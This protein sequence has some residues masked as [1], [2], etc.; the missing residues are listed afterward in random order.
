VQGQFRVNSE[1]VMTFSEYGLKEKNKPKV[2]VECK[3]SDTVLSP[4][5]LWFQE[6][7]SVPV[8]IQVIQAPGHASR[9]TLGGRT[10]W[11][12]SADRWLTKLV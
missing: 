1:K 2:L 7:L 6:S 3:L 8:A 11:V 4:N 10:Q 12:V 9:T 5:L